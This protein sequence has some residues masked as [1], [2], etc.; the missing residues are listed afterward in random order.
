MLYTNSYYKHNTTPFRKKVKTPHKNPKN[1]IK[2]TKKT[3][4]KQNNISVSLMIEVH[5]VTSNDMVSSND[6]ELH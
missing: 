1:K 6:K 2:K 3:P 4:N 5:V